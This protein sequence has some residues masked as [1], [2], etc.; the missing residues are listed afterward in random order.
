LAF[1]G[2]SAARLL[3]SGRTRCAT[4]QIFKNSFPNLSRKPFTSNLCCRGRK[5]ASFASHPNR[6]NHGCEITD[7]SDDAGV[8]SHRRRV[9]GECRT[10]RDQNRVTEK[11]YRTTAP[12]S[13]RFDA[14]ANSLPVL[15]SLITNVLFSPSVDHGPRD[16]SLKSTKRQSVTSVSFNPR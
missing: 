2:S 5:A 12:P 4:I 9:S 13:A 10:Y 7:V 3:R 8:R 14:S 1:P 16:T 11:A 6:L 15:R